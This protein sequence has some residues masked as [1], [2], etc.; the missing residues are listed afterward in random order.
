MNNIVFSFIITTLAGLST[1]LG[2]LFIFINKDKEKLLT[3]SISFAAGIMVT[4]SFID[5]IPS[6]YSY[7]NTKY[8]SFTSIL[9]ILLSILTGIIPFS[10]KKSLI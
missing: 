3:A 9:L 7:L 1:L 4:I 5:L 8:F 6:A 2:F 10:R